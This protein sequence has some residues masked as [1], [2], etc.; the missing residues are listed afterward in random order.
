MLA[1]P[2]AHRLA[3]A[4]LA[5][6]LAAAAPLRAQDAARLPILV[7]ITG[8]V[9]LEGTSQRNGALLALKDAQDRFKLV[10]DVIDTGAAPEGA[11]TGF[12][13]ALDDKP[14]AMVAPILGTQMLALLP[15]AQRYKL[16][17]LTISGTARITEL[18]NPFVFR[19]F[20]GDAVVKRAQA[21]YAVQKLGARKPA[22]IYQTTAYGQSGRDELARQF[23]A[24]GAPLVYEEGLAPTVK[25]VLPSLTKAVAAGA[26]VLILQLHA[27]ST[28]LVI[29]Q[30]RSLG[31]ALPIVAGSAMHQPAT[32]AL[33]SPQ[34]LAG[35]CAETASSPISG[36]SAAMQR[37]AQSYRSEFNSDPDAFA[38][39]QY[40]ATM[41]L[42]AALLSGAR[43]GESVRAYLASNSYDG[44][45]MRYRSDGA[46]NMA[47]DAQIV[48][49]DGKTRV[50]AIVER[51]PGKPS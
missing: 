29:G 28:A 26:D 37:F 31:I 49:F 30:A 9:A 24:L 5:V 10:P 4:A 36:G 46:G 38:V 23:T 8:F 2:Y 32:A 1:R 13:R 25:D 16:P 34:E 44:L 51:Y 11:V 12:E 7:P 20:P 17:L 3:C 50:P 33:L 21:T 47:H 22:L 19:F 35:V 42:I 15:L 6:L 27:P 18:G 39:A 41:M 14:V 45:A 43:D 48:C 40:D